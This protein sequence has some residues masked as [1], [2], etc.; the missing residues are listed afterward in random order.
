MPPL[1]RTVLVL[2]AAFSPA[3][4]EPLRVALIAPSAEVAVLAALGATIEDGGL[5]RISTPARLAAWR[6]PPRGG[7][8]RG[9]GQVGGGGC[10]KD[11]C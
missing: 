9:G 4:A 10:R 7:G 8:G 11:G 1:L 6:R 2:A 3:G 5:V